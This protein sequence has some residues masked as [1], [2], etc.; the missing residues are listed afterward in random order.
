MSPVVEEISLNIATIHETGKDDAGPDHHVAGADGETGITRELLA[1]I[2]LMSIDEIDGLEPARNDGISRF[3]SSFSG[4]ING[5]RVEK[6]T[7][8]VAVDILV[9]V[10]YGANIPDLAAKLRETV[11]RRIWQMTGMRVVEANVRIQDVSPVALSG[12]TD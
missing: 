7:T 1:R 12:E 6:G 11:G 5:I 3:L 2:T 10:R 8:E 9:R 4:R